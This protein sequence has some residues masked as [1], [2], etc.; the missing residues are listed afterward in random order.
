[1]ALAGLFTSAETRKLHWRV[2]QHIS[3]AFL[4]H[5][6]TWY[7]FPFWRGY[8]TQQLAEFSLLKE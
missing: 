3:C 2:F 5:H 6:R 1:V 4:C 8:S 7:R